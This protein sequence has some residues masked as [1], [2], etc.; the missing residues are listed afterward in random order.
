MLQEDQEE[1]RSRVRRLP[2]Y[3]GGRLLPETRRVGRKG[4]ANSA[5]PQTGSTRPQS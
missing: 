1:S 5:Y 4:K 2:F 3:A